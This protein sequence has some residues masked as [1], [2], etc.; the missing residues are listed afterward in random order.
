MQ[1]L[2]TYY[3]QQ[4]EHART[5]LMLQQLM[6]RK[7]KVPVLF[8]CICTDTKEGES[9]GNVYYAEQLTEWFQNEGR[10]LLLR[11]RGE[12]SSVI[13]MA[14]RQ[15]L[16]QTDCEFREYMRHNWLTNYDMAEKAAI[17]VISLLCIGDSFLLFQRGRVGAYLLNTR[18]GHAH[19]KKLTVSDSQ[20]YVILSGE[21][22]KNIGLLLVTEDFESKLS[23]QQLEECLSVTESLS[24]QRYRRR[25]EELGEEA[26]R[27]GGR[28]MGAVLLVTE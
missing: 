4:E 27:Q 5:S 13:E 21:M 12:N 20:D 9:L 16:L 19:C 15:K 18:L 10:E 22:E 11:S 25:L 24:P 23:R 17:A 7:G 28:H 6:Y 2:S 14:F 8:A 26:G 1:Y 3:W